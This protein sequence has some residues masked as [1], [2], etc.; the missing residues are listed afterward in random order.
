MRRPRIWP[1]SSPKRSKNSFIRQPVVAGVFYPEA[2]QPLGDLINQVLDPR[3]K[4]E[5]VL[6]VIVPHGG[7]IDSGVVAGRV[8]SCIV[9]PR[10]AVVM[11]PTHTGREKRFNLMRKGS[12]ETPLGRLQVDEELAEAISDQIPQMQE[13][14]KAHEQE[15]AIEVQVPF[16]QKAGK[17]KSFVP[18]LFEP[19]DPATAQQIGRGIAKAVRQMKEEVLLIATTDLTRYQSKEI[20]AGNDRHAIDQILA[21]DERRLLEAVEEHSLSMCGATPTAVALSAAKNLEGSKGT[22]V[23]YRTSGVGGDEADSVIG[24]AG[25]IIQ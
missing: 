4:K 8:Y 7:M 3:R 25:I 13:D 23:D 12:W 6:A 5:R 19:A 15:H 9:W 22:L 20:A 18:I 11:G 2:K 17:M 14:L 10:R 24:F 21:L 16:L 1:K